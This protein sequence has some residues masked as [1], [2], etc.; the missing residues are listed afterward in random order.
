MLNDS[1][2]ADQDGCPAPVI[3]E[4][5]TIEG[6]HRSC[7]SDKNASPRS[8]VRRRKDPG[9]VDDNGRLPHSDIPGVDLTGMERRTGGWASECCTCSPSS[10]TPSVTR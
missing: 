7:G 8:H 1:T 10:T 4:P 2:A 5:E 9:R 3:P 6:M